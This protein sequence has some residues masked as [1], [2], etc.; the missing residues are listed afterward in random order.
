WRQD[1]PLL[2]ATS[3]FLTQAHNVH[4]LRWLLKDAGEGV[5]R[6]A[7]SNFLSN[8]ADAGAKGNREELKSLL[9]ALQGKRDAQV[10]AGL[11][12]YADDYARLP[13]GA[14]Q[15]AT[16]AAKD[17]EQL[18]ADIPDATLA[19]DWNYL[20]REMR[21]DLLVPP[22]QALA[23]LDAVRQSLLKTGGARLFMIGSSP[24][25]Q[26]LAPGVA[27]LLAGLEGGGVV[28]AKYSGVR[29]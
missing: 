20:A 29:L 1:S 17:L 18:L 9:A 25:Q 8:L 7:V 3:S 16:E 21:R 24:N 11:R 27:A 22:A 23:D 5:G 15:I 14:R 26:R 4:R 10:P 19:A 6:E 28:P 12:A 13:E 2:L